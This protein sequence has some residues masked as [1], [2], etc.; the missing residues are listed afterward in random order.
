[1]LLNTGSER[2]GLLYGRVDVATGLTKID[3][4]GQFFAE[5]PFEIGA[6]NRRDGLT[7]IRFPRNA[8]QSPVGDTPLQ[9]VDRS[10][11]ASFFPHNRALQ[12]DRGVHMLRSRFVGDQQVRAPKHQTNRNANSGGKQPRQYTEQKCAKPT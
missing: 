2:L 4:I 9:Q 11:D 6:G 5:S 7:P 10:R 1:M 8:Q 3:P 12:H